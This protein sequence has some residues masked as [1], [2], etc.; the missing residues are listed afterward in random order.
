MT[1]SKFNDYIRESIWRVNPG[2]MH[3]R[4]NFF[5]LDAIEPQLV[6]ARGTETH[7]VV[8]IRDFR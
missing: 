8:L 4:V 2:E 6:Q 3:N 1:C 7:D 5:F